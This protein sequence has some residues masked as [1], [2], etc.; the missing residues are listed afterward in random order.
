MLRTE[1]NWGF[2]LNHFWFSTTLSDKEIG[3]DPDIANV[4]LIHA[5]HIMHATHFEPG[6]TDLNRGKQKKKKEGKKGRKKEKKPR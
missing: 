6:R 5:S 2:V 1:A 3:D 4:A